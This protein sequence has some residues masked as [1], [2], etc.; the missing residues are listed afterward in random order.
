MSHFL[1][2]GYGT[3]KGGGSFAA[4]KT[5]RWTVFSPW[6]SPAPQGAIRYDLAPVRMSL[7]F[8]N[9]YGTRRER[10]AQRA[11]KKVSS[12]HFFSSG[13]SPAPQGASRQGLRTLLLPRRGWGKRL[14]PSQSLRDSS[15]R[16]GAKE[17]ADCHV[18]RWPPRND[19]RYTSVPGMTRV[20]PSSVS[21]LRETREPPSPRG[22]A[23]LRFFD[24]SRKNRGIATPVTSVTGSQ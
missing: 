6:E 16:A 11:G 20:L 5:V 10:P 15:P 13:E 9:G 8:W 24:G 1:W 17:K 22:K 19:M 3:R 21:R 14:S 4:A 18:G 23:F 12:G 7:L 2:N